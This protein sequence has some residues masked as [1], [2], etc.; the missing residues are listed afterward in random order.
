[1]DQKTFLNL[2]THTYQQCIKDNAEDFQ[3]SY[4][5]LSK[6]VSI[7][8]LKNIITEEEVKYILDV[9]DVPEFV[10]VFGQQKETDEVE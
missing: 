4:W 2:I 8:K 1:M 5:L 7:L 9:T 6:L 3:R 10:D